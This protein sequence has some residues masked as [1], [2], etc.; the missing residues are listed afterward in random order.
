[1]TRMTTIMGI[2][3]GVW[4]TMRI[5]APIQVMGA[6]TRIRMVPLIK[7]WIWVTSLVMRVIRDAG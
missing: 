1:M 5:M 6:L 4:V 7:F 2:C 3:L